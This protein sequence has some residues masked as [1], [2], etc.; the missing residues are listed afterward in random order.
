MFAIRKSLNILLAMSIVITAY[1]AVYVDPKN[2]TSDSANED[3]NDSSVT[4]VNADQEAQKGPS[5]SAVSSEASSH[6]LRPIAIYTI[7]ANHEYSNA[8][9]PSNIRALMTRLFYQS[10]YGDASKQHGFLRGE[11][12]KIVNGESNK[13][14]EEEPEPEAEKD[15]KGGNK[16]E[17]EN[18]ADENEK[19]KGNEE[20]GDKGKDKPEDEEKPEEGAEKQPQT[21]AQN[22][23]KGGK[24]K[25]VNKS[26][27]KNRF[28]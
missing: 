24:R 3:A 16:P 7:F 26:A 19:E 20:G 2:E 15:K 27:L 25:A 10:S 14:P 18:E 28:V 4:I 22:L 9:I 12:L 13:K 23:Q 6:G 11:V 21:G 1:C 8:P 17:D 5:H